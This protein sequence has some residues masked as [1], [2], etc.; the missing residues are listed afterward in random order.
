MSN[1]NLKNIVVLKNLPSNLVDEAIIFLKSK[2]NVKKLEHIENRTVTG[3]KGKINE[4][5]YIIKEAENI[6][7]NY[8]AKI[9]CNKNNKRANNNIEVKYKKVKAYS[10][11]V[12]IILLFSILKNF[13]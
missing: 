11:L 1:D 3:L 9:E 6:V 8:I 13:F 4:E 10:V 7:S 2:K 12:S 5:D